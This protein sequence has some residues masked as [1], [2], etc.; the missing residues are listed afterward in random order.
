MLHS[1]FSDR[2]V[3]ANG[4]KLSN[5]NRDYANKNCSET[6]E[7]HNKDSKETWSQWRIYSYEGRPGQFRHVKL[8]HKKLRLDICPMYILWKIAAY[9]FVT[10]E[11]HLLSGMTLQIAS[12]Q[13]LDDCVTIS[14]NAAKFHKVKTMEANFSARKM[15]SNDDLVSA[16]EKT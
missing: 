15:T 9:Y 16:I 1:L 2:T 12:R 7:S 6:E 3:P 11:W 14:D 13:S 5:T 8:R 10:C 4:L